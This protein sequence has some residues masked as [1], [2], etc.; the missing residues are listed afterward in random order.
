MHIAD[1]GSIPSI[2]FGPLTQPEVIPEFRLRSGPSTAFHS[3]QPS[4]TAAG[5]G[6]LTSGLCCCSVDSSF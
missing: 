5:L 3:L 1:P 2:L 6:L 4:S